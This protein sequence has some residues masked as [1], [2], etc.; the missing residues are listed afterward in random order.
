[1]TAVPPNPPHAPDQDEFEQEG[2]FRVKQYRIYPLTEALIIGITAFLAIFFTT[3]FIYLHALAAQKGEIRE[4]LART[5]AVLAQF[6]NGDLHETFVSPTQ[7]RTLAYRRA[8]VPFMK[9]L[10]ADPSIR[11]VYTGVMR[12][13]KVYL[14]LD[15]TPPGDADGDG[16]DDKAHIM[17]YYPDAAKAMVTALKERRVATSKEPYVDEWGSFLSSYIPFYDSKGKFVGVV[18]IDIDATNYFK[19]LE[20]IKQATVRTMMT[21]FFI[22]FLVGA[23]VW[24]MRNFSRII[25]SSRHS[26][27]RDYRKLRREKK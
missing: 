20:P 1:M 23:L 25:N 24:F 2:E 4:G 8:L 12:D 27:F 16:V 19:R 5:G 7:E 9:T 15:P 3:Y 10:A 6:V 17:E 26:L 21:G 13:G 18:G 14:V 22:A 11:F